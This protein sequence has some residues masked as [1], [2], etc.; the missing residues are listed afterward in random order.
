[1]D[2]SEIFQIKTKKFWWMD[3]VFYFVISLLISTIFCY[4]IFLIKNSWQREEIV[5]QEEALQTVGTELQK[6]YEADVIKYQRKINDFSNLL[7]NHKFASNVF[8]FMRAQTMPNVWFKRFD[9]DERNNTVQLSGES[10]N[11]DAL[12]RQ[13]ATFEK[14]K[15]V[16]SIESFNSLLGNSARVDFNINLALKEDIFS[17][18]VSPL[19]SSDNPPP[20]Q[21]AP[22]S[23]DAGGQ[24]DLQA[25]SEKLLISFNL[26][27]DPEV[28]GVINE[29]DHSVVLNVPYGTDVKN[30][31]PSATISSKARLF[32]PSDIAIDFTDPVTYRVI[33]QDNSMQGYQVRVIVGAA[34]EPEKGSGRSVFVALFIAVLVIIAIAGT[35]FLLIL[36]RKKINQF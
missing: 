13:V 10:D 25:S 9:L 6:E 27:L 30:L 20:D 29:E 19:P 15:Y 28:I 17:Y 4:F 35:V 34:P 22:I 5:K 14:N 24:P 11:M 36:K 33:A 8:S 12:S 1:M 26:L 31:K 21:G 32:P 16:K 2:F 23:G 18:I 3:V 7:E